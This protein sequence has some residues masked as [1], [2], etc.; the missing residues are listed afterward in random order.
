MPKLATLFDWSVRL[1][2][3]AALFSLLFA[4]EDNMRWLGLLGAVPLLLALQP[5]C[6]SCSLRHSGKS[7]GGWQTWP[8]H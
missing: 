8:G 4:F 7:N 3:A 2:P 6:P 1:I 5:G